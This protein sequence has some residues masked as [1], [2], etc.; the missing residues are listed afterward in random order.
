MDMRRFEA[1]VIASI[2]TGERRAGFRDRNTGVFKEVMCIR[3][4]RDYEAFLDEF[5]LSKGDVKEEY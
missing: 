2:C 4:D 1:V 3:D 5:G